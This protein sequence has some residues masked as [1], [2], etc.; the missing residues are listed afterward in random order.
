MW[1]LRYDELCSE[2]KQKVVEVLAK[3]SLLLVRSLGRKMILD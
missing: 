3:N 2:H 1:L